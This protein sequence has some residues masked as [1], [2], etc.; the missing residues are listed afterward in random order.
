SVIILSGGLYPV[1][2]THWRKTVQVVR[3]FGEK[4]SSHFPPVMRGRF[5]QRFL[6]KNS[7]PQLVASAEGQN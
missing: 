5:D 1:L 7:V 6:K 2:N 3:F 4:I